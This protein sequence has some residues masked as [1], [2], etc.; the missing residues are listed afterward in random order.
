MMRF[1]QSYARTHAHAYSHTPMRRR[2]RPEVKKP[3][4]IFKFTLRHRFTGPPHALLFFCTKCTHDIC[5]FM[6]ARNGHALHTLALV[7]VLGSLE[8]AGERACVVR[9]RSVLLNHNN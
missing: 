1:V 4:G 5:S 3:T 9:R 2:C 6:G 7:L 8:G